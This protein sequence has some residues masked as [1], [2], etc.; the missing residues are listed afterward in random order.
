MPPSG[1][2][3]RFTAARTAL[4][5]GV[6]VGS[7]AL[8]AV[9]PA[10][11]ASV[12]TWE[13]VA[14][15]ES[16]NNWSINT[17]NT[18]Y[19]GLQISLYNWRYYGGVAYAARPDLATERQQILIAEK[20][21]ADQGARAWT[22]SPGTGLATDHSNPY[23]DPA[24][25]PAPPAKNN[26]VIEAVEGGALHEVYT[27][28][29]GS[30]HDSAVPGVPGGIG[31][32]AFAYNAAGQRVIEAVENGA[33]HEIYSDTAGNWYDN[34]VPGVGGGISAL[35]F[36]YNASG[37]RVIEAVEGGV[38]HEIYVDG[39]GTW[40]DN[41]VPGVGG[42]ISSVA[43]H[44]KPDNTRVIEAV[45]DGALHEI[46]SDTAGN[47]YDNAVPGVGGGI[48]ALGFAY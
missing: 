19:G 33:L 41:A 23:P 38:L 34:A 15:C 17:H 32:V 12:A 28:S 25:T 4:A 48:S 30:W 11:A 47:W 29:A 37:Q 24:P 8:G 42:G 5:I 20:I 1:R 39:T 7:L 3:T 27:D 22:C 35:G 10:Q 2:R 26:R 14:A 21:L 9:G 45:E 16:G 6:A 13:K 46:Y 40:H 36:A 18:Y 43:V 31:A 44:V